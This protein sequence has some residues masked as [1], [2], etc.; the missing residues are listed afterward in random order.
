MNVCTNCGVKAVGHSPT[1]VW[2]N[3]CGDMSPCPCW[4]STWCPAHSGNH[5]H[6]WDE[7]GYCST[8]DCP[9]KK[10]FFDQIVHP[11]RQERE[12]GGSSDDREM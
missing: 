2:C 1:G 7:N 5:T 10:K 8:T 4:Q 9:A 11:T 3:A 6:Q 12:G